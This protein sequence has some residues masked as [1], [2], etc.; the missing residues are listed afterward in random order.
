MCFTLTEGAKTVKTF[1]KLLNVSSIDQAI[2]ALAER[3]KMLA[4]EIAEDSIGVWTPTRSQGMCA[5][6]IGTWASK[7]KLDGAVWTALK[8]RLRDNRDVVP[9]KEQVLEI[10]EA[11]I[12]LGKEKDARQYVEN[13]PIDTEYLQFIRKSLRWNRP[14]A[15]SA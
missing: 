11:L 1:W 3:E 13:S 14:P 6:V 15:R 5:D 10:L 2:D 8:P 7:K 12:V 4:H 9:T